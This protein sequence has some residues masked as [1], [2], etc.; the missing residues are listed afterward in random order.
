[1]STKKYFFF[2]IDGTLTV[3][4]TGLIVP[5]AAEAIKNF[6]KQGI[7][8]PLPQ[9]VRD[10]RQRGSGPERVFSHGVQRRSWYCL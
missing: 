2:D 3:R 8:C 1:M 4:E 9:G 10:T 5:S 6:R 7:L